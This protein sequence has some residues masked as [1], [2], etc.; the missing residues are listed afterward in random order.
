MSNV[1]SSS[2]LSISSSQ[3]I[4]DAK[5]ILLNS[6]LNCLKEKDNSKHVNL[7]KRQSFI[8]ALN[9]CLEFQKVPKDKYQLKERSEVESSGRKLDDSLSFVMV[10]DSSEESND[11][12]EFSNEKRINVKDDDR[13]TLDKSKTREDNENRNETL[14]RLIKKFHTIR[15]KEINREVLKDSKNSVKKSN[16]RVDED[17]W[18]SFEETSAVTSNPHSNQALKKSK[19]DRDQLFEETTSSCD[20]SNT[21]TKTT[22]NSKSYTPIKSHKIN[23]ENPRITAKNYLNEQLSKTN[24]KD[25][26]DYL[27]YNQLSIESPGIKSESVTLNET[28][29]IDIL[30][31]LHNNT[32]SGSLPLSIKN[33]KN[34]VEPSTDDTDNS[35][36]LALN[37]RRSNNVRELQSK[38]QV[39]SNLSLHYL[40]YMMSFFSAKCLRFN[41]VKLACLRPNGRNPIKIH[42]GS[43]VDVYLGSLEPKGYMVAVKMYKKNS[44]TNLT[45]ILQEVRVLSDLNDCEDEPTP[46]FYGLLN[47]KSRKYHSYCVVNQFLGDPLSFHTLRLID[48]LKQCKRDKKLWRLGQATGINRKMLLKLA[49]KIKM[50]HS[51]GILRFELVLFKSFNQICRKLS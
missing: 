4:S 13:C 23:R 15:D 14:Q 27:D 2:Y 31:R 22:T 49:E 9:G 12:I 50:I 40:D 7:E 45:N 21:L 47:I 51:K 37:Q 29:H 30:N 20:E 41:D 44:N 39:L 24:S 10:T 18:I 38:F 16:K 25:N 17:S 6:L 35:V 48:Y 3:A 33:K 42:I 19:N 5:Q 43:S 28:E 1:T 46:Y 34:K 26:K 36:T 32:V 11:S 8:D